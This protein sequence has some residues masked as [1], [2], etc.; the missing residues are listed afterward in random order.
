VLVDV[1]LFGPEGRS[2]RVRVSADLRAPVPS[3]PVAD[4]PSSYAFTGRHDRGPLRPEPSSP[5]YGHLV[6][7]LV[8]AKA[9]TDAAILRLGGIAPPTTEPNPR[10]RTRRGPY[11]G[12]EPEPKV[13]LRGRG[14]GLG[15]RGVRSC[16]F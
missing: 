5:A 16:W 11:A 9:Q 6:A 8:D 7:A 15:E 14:G 10:T 4:G 13:R 3:E 1:E 2:E 12:A